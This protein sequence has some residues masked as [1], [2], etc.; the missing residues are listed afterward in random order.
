MADHPKAR[1]VAGGTDLFVRWPHRYVHLDGP[2]IDLTH[3]PELRYLRMSGDQLS[4]GAT[5]T[6]WDLLSDLEICD[7]FSMLALAARQ[8]GA[9]QVQARGTWAGNVVNASPAADGVMALIACDAAVEVRSATGCWVY[10]L[11]AFYTGY[12]TTRLRPGQLVTA[13]KVPRIERRHVCFHKVGGRR[14]QTIS[15][16]G[17]AVCHSQDAWRVAVNGMAPTVR[18][19]PAIE[20]A[21]DQNFRPERIRDWFDLIRG[22]LEP[23]DDHR[24]TRNYREQVLARLL[25]AIS[26][27]L[28]PTPRFKP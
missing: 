8:V 28:E 15:K 10:P 20:K 25:S 22:D 21:L 11:S 3:L 19:C 9:I 23:I 13:L 14:G 26:S 17:L 2:L 7:Q 6:Y 4:I 27:N 18:R 5:A 1:P 16:V 12:R 24:S